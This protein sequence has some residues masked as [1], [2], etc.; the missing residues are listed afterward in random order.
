[1]S[2][3]LLTISFW[4][5]RYR[6]RRLP[7]AVGRGGIGIKTGEGDG[8]TPVGTF[9][10]VEVFCRADRGQSLPGARQIAPSWVWS[11]DPG[12]PDY[13]RLCPTP[14]AGLR[15][16]RMRRGDGLYDLVASLD[17]NLDDPVPGAGSAIFLH[18][19]RAPRTPTAG[20]VA[21]SLPELRWILENWGP[22]DRVVITA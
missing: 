10:I 14:K 21:F 11:D 13:N 6:G 2:K 18:V 7:C 17:F 8:I 3:E 12:D 22:R 9:R 4:G 16:E 19:W 1:M 5:A 20:C 15:H